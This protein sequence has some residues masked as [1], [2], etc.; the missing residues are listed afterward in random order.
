MHSLYWGLVTFALLGKS[1]V[2]IAGITFYAYSAFI[3]Y[4]FYR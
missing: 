4:L 1:G 3:N 2:I